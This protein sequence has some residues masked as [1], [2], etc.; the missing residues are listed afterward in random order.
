M[1]TVHRLRIT[2]NV[3]GVGYRAHARRAAQQ[4]GIAGWVRNLDDGSVE[5]QYVLPEEESE[6]AEL[7]RRFLAELRR[8]PRYG[9]VD[10]IDEEIL[11]VDADWREFTVRFF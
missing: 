7:Q 9:R 5:V 11:Q 2:G 8:G 3:Q 10:A 4:L 1:S 6:E